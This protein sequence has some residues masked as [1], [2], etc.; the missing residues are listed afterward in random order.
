MKIE[1]TDNEIVIRIPNTIALEDLE[2]FLNYLE[3]KEKTSDVNVS[4]SEID[5]LAS[6]FN[7]SYWAKYRDKYIK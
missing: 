7:K 3:Y 6:E 2:D 5:K 1:K 4:Q